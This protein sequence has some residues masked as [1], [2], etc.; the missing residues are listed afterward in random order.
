[1]RRKK[2]YSSAEDNRLVELK[3]LKTPTTLIAKELGRSAASVSSHWSCR[4]LTK[5]RSGKRP[6]SK[7]D[8]EE[9]L[10]MW[11]AGTKVRTIA[12][13]FGRTS[14]SVY[15]RL[16]KTLLSRGPRPVMRM[17]SVSDPKRQ[18][19][20]EEFDRIAALMAAG[21]TEK[22]V[23]EIFQL[24]LGTFKNVWR[25]VQARPSLAAQRDPSHRY[26]TLPE[27]IRIIQLRNEN[28]LSYVQIAHETGW[29]LY[30]V[31]KT[32]NNS[33]NSKASPKKDHVPYSDEEDL[34]LIELRERHGMT[35]PQIAARTQRRSSSSYRLRY[36]WY[37]ENR[38][39]TST[40][41]AYWTKAED[42]KL[43]NLFAQG[44]MPHREIAT[45]LLGRTPRAVHARIH[46]LNGSPR[47]PAATAVS[48][49]AA[50]QNR[51]DQ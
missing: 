39:K 41:A 23:A 19:S 46:R 47:K 33:L 34:E 17:D 29:S 18:F 21:N 6:Y 22:A 37:L 9:I 27:K 35:F 40:K 12:E 50:D 25:R 45:H 5:G 4:G 16:H 13:A 31:S 7:T 11:Q 44:D 14:S 1:M 26:C 49:K 28:R 36:R 24:P 48:A 51:V 15:G 30:T 8:D 2:H 10:Q 43:Q 20:L 32:L 42:L 38:N 3:R